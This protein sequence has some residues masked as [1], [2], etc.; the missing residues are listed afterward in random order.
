MLLVRTVSGILHPIKPLTNC[1]MNGILR[2]PLT[3]KGYFSGI[4]PFRNGKF[5]LTDLGSGHFSTQCSQKSRHALGIRG[6]NLPSW[7]RNT[8]NKLRLQCVRHQT[9]GGKTD[10]VTKSR[11]IKSSELKKL[12]ALAKPER[13]KIAGN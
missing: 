11:S 9:N 2:V 12:L 4:F 10:A 3:G 1:C 13:W 8:N 6:S 5:R 7:V